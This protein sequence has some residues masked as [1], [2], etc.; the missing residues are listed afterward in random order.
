MIIYPNTEIFFLFLHE[1]YI[2]VMSN[3]DT[4]EATESIGMKAY[5]FLVDNINGDKELIDNAINDIVKSDTTGQFTAS[6]ARFLS[7]IDPESF[8]PHINILLQSVIDKDREKQY[9]PALLPS[10]WGTDYMNRA[11]ELRDLDD[12]FRRIFK[13]VHPIGII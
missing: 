10:I 2:S 4:Q 1:N 12:N 5:E 3:K 9:M 7:A 8:A 6:A 13:R 11:E